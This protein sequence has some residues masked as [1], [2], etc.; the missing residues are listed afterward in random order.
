MLAGTNSFRNPIDFLL[1]HAERTPSAPA[2]VTIGRTLTYAELKNSVFRRAG[3]FRRH[4][5]QSGMRAAVYTDDDV[6][7]TIS[8][9]AIWTSGAVC[10]P[11]NITQKPDKLNAIEAIVAPDMGFYTDDVVQDAQRPFPMAALVGDDVFSESV[12]ISGPDDYGIIMFTSG[13]SGVP[14]AVPMTY[15]ALGHNAWETSARLG[16]T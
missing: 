13:T 7:L 5:L 2:L 11:M 3:W 6:E 10:V 16:V 15:A 8:L 14:K 4:G 12:F 9:F 1:G